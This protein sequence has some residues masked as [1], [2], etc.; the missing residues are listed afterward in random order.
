MG[1]TVFRLYGQTMK[2]NGQDG[3]VSGST[4]RERTLVKGN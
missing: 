1:S 2:V 4:S 3:D